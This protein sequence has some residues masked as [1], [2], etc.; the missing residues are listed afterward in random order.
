MNNDNLLLII[1]ILIYW[2]TLLWLASKRKYSKK[3]L[4]INGLINIIYTAYF[5]YGLIYL[6]QGGGSL[7]WWFYLLL[8]TG[9]HWL[10]NLAT[11]TYLLFKP[12][13]KNKI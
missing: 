9:S 10:I 7:V 12:S 11:I 8:F 6:S 2:G 4:I 13:P 1:I 5:L 3:T